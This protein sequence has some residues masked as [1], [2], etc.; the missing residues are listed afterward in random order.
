MEEERMNSAA[1][2][3]LLRAENE[4]NHGKWLAQNQA[5]KIWGWDTPAGRRR[6]K[7]RGRL[8]MEGA[9]LEPGKH[10]LEIGCGTGLFT[11]MFAE[12]GVRVTAVDISP[13]LLEQARQRNLPAD[14]VRFLEKRFEDCDLEG[15]FDA[16]VGSSVLHHLEVDEALHRIFTLLKPNG[17]LSLAEPNLLNPQVYLE[18]RFHFLPMFSYTSPDETA[19]VRWKLASQLRQT[20]FTD[21]SIRPFD[22]LHPFTPKP[23]IG[24]M[25]GLGRIAE[26]VPLAREFSG[27]LHIIAARPG[28]RII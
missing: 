24:V 8:L 3:E 27:S 11:A 7:R 21:I 22:W 13:E 26:G 20:G 18:R 23:L 12:R 10:A 2:T 28:P 17:R 4:I 16:V 9:Q 15:P 1:K 6:A 25:L 5:E 14:R 19:F